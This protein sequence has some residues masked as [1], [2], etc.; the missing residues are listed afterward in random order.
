VRPVKAIWDNFAWSEKIFH[1]FVR[2]VAIG[3]IGPR[4][5]LDARSIRGAEREKVSTEKDLDRTTAVRSSG[6]GESRPAAGGS[7]PP[8]ASQPSNRPRTA[9]NRPDLPDNRRKTAKK[10]LRLLAGLVN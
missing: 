5:A 9:S 7:P 6:G 2:V 3:E 10:M 4:I 1:R 8:T